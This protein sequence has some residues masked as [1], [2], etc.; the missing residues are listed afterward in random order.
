MDQITAALLLALAVSQIIEYLVAPLRQNVA[1]AA[2][3]VRWGLAYYD[4]PDS[5]IISMLS[6][7]VAESTFARHTLANP[8]RYVVIWVVPY[9]Q[10]IF[11]ALTSYV[12]KVDVISQYVPVGK[13]PALI[14]TAAVVGCGADVIRKIV[15]GPTYR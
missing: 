8:R 6:G 11:G 15:S 2:W 12:F 5:L 1:I 10:F 4:V 13:V 3:L 14:L 9:I 7:K